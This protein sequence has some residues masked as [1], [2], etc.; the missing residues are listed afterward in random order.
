MLYTV[1]LDK[2]GFI[3]SIS[4]SL[5]DSIDL[6]LDSMDLK[7]INAYQIIDGIAVLNQD[8]LAELISE[9][10]QESNDEEIFE[11][12]QKLNETDYVVARAFEEV[13]ALNN[14]LTWIA[15]VIKIMVKYSAEYA[16][17]LANRKTWRKRIE[18]LRKES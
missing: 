1:N 11:L 4:H 6:N 13:M 9:E 14:P 18:E 2:D 3:L 10:E 17:T 16:E 15:D 5:N 7:H 8:K 12:Q